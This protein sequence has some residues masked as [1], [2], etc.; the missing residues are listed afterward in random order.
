MTMIDHILIHKDLMPKVKK[1]FID[2]GH[3][4]QVSDHWAVVVDLVLD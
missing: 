3:G 2:H 1:V 4:S